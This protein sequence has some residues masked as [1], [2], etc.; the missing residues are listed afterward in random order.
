MKTA[1][2]VGR[3]Q[4]FHRGHLAVI[5]VLQSQGYEVLI[6][7]GS[8]EKQREESNPWSFEERKLM[9]ASCF[10][11]KIVAI[12]DISEDSKWVRHVQD[13]VGE[14]IDLVCTGNDNVAAL[15]M[16][17]GYLVLRPEMVSYEGHPITASRIR[18]LMRQDKPWERLVP[19]ESLEITRTLAR[20]IAGQGNA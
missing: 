6:G 2:F 20:V 13:T 15:F 1:L 11:G 14:N 8:S 9:I 12:S 5:H 10:S 3:F 4:P 19:Q 7:V 18:E 17:A 16:K